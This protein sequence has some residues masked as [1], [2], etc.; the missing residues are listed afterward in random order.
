MKWISITKTHDIMSQLLLEKGV[1]PEVSSTVIDSLIQTSI[2]GVDS[3][4]IGLFPHYY[5]EISLNRLNINPNILVEKTADSVG[6]L[7]AKNT[8]GHYAGKLAMNSAIDMAN[9]TGVGIVNVRNSTHFGAAWFFT[10]MAANK[11]MIGLAFT[12]TESLVNAYNSKNSFFGTNPIC[13]SAPI[14]NEEPFCLDMATSNVSW[15][16]IK[17]YK[18]QNLVLEDGWAL[19][20]N[21]INTTDPNKA[22]SLTAIGGYKGFG[23]GMVVEILCSGLANGPMSKN[24]P[25]L[26]DLSIDT[27]RNI[28]HLFIAIDISKFLP[29]EIFNNYM[30]NLSNSVRTLDTITNEKEIMISGDPEKKLYKERLHTG[31]PVD[32]FKFEEFLNI[33]KDFKYTIL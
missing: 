20:N 16:K 26:Y 24:I 13:F 21:G 7:D 15:N 31:I 18:R 1:L 14:P 2:R 17:N 6:I 30:L 19:D 4:G 3:H 33:S 8:L 32:D 29:L 23:L 11:G 9:I 22:T 10:N 27:N 28:S 12:N 5:N 25:P